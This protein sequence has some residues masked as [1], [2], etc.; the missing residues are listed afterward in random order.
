MGFYPAPP[1]PKVWYD[2]DGSV[3]FLHPTSGFP[4]SLASEAAAVNSERTSGGY[5]TSSGGRIGVLLTAPTDIVGAYILG[6]ASSTST[7]LVRTSPDT[8]TGEDGTWTE[9]ATQMPVLGT[10]ASSS[11]YRSSVFTLNYAA[12]K[13]ITFHQAAGMTVRQLH[14][15]GT[16]AS[17][18]NPDRLRLWQPVANSEITP[19]YFDFA[20]VPQTTTKIVQFRVK[21]GSAT[22]TA[23]TITVATAA[24]TSPSPTMTSQT[25][26][27]LDGST[28]TPSIN[29]GNLA[30]GALSGVLHAR[31]VV[32]STA[33]TGPWRQRFSASAA[34]F[35]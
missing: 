20:E 30:P 19:G 17:G 7:A 12:I 11:A 34:S 9:Q 2:T 6:T 1:G 10:N 15:Y 13:G 22:L 14:I 24:L 35:T 16:F 26:F 31:I 18:Q 23:N 29:V 32:A 8:T 25:S 28:Y 4:S 5:V 33:A 3:L 21:N 27:S